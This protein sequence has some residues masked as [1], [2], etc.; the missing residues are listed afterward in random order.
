MRHLKNEV[1][2]MR[3]PRNKVKREFVKFEICNYPETKKQVQTIQPPY[4]TTAVID[5]KLKIVNAV[6]DALLRIKQDSLNGS[7]K[8]KLI[9]VYFW[10]KRDLTVEGLALDQ[11]VH[12]NTAQ[13]WINEFI[14][15]VGENLGLYDYN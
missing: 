6:D 10:G 2:L 13:I 12:R 3:V 14:K 15:R 4:S 11:H 1:L 7:N 5:H 9:T 8:E